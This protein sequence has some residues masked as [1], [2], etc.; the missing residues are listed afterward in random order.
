M[1][2][3]EHKTVQARIL[4]H[5]EAKINGGRVF[6]P[7]L[8]KTRTRMSVLL[9]SRQITFFSDKTTN[10]RQIEVLYVIYELFMT[11]NLPHAEA[12]LGKRA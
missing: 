5:T 1:K 11:Y 3:G 2:P 4:G 12:N 9:Y 6:Q 7:A 10:A 8:R